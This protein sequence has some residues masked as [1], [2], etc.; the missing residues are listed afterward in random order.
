M[1]T[2]HEPVERNGIESG[3]CTRLQLG[4]PWNVRVAMTM[5]GLRSLIVG[6]IIGCIVLPIAADAEGLLYVETAGGSRLDSTREIVRWTH[7][8][9]VFE[10]DLERIAVGQPN[11]LE[12]ELL[13]GREALMLAKDIGTTSMIVWYTD[14]TTEPLVFGVIEDLSVLRRVLRDIHRSLTIELAPDRAAL[15]LRGT[16][17]DVE[18][19]AHAENAVR[20]YL[21]AEGAGTR[22]IYNPEAGTGGISS[23]ATRTAIINLIRTD[24]EAESLESRILAA[25]KPLAANVT[26]RRLV[27]GNVRDD[28]RDTFV[29]EGEV[30]DQV[31]LTRV[32]SMAS[33]I[34]SGSANPAISVVSDASGGLGT[35]GGEQRNIGRS[36]LLSVADG[37]VLSMIKVRFLPQVRVAVQIHEVNRS[38]LREWRPDLSLISS[39]YSAG[40]LSNLPGGI[41]APANLERLFT[42]DETE[43]GNALQVI[44]GTLTN[45]FQV[46]TSRLAFEVLFSILEEE[47]ISRSLASPTLTVL[48]GEPAVFE[49]GG[50]LPVPSVFVPYSGTVADGDSG[51]SGPGTYANVVFKRFGV[52]LKVF[53]LV[54]ESNFI[55]LD[56]NPEISQ[57]D[58]TLTRQITS[59]VGSRSQAAAFMTRSL[60]TRM[61]VRDGQPLVIGGLISQGDEDVEAYTPGL[62]NVPGVGLLGR[63]S[64]RTS[65]STELVIIVTPTIVQ[66]ANDQVALWQ[67]PELDALL[68]GAVGIPEVDVLPRILTPRGNEGARAKP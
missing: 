42:P 60:E 62:R 45:S 52:S 40:A 34:V 33:S 58:L 4:L 57:P 19:K 8:R 2:E 14:G 39:R 21:N 23:A 15:V 48:S 7:A 63:E 5:I 41:S 30:K 18:V 67:Y 53:P 64:S 55:T 13:G 61:R 38:R 1:R 10:K 46:G 65:Y 51:F 59:A 44:N 6:V 3:E 43:I 47:G 25:I 32:L 20:A 24:V 66:E 26:V 17:P 27:R 36:R 12:V 49:V 16:V 37:R 35:Q 28:A 29:L 31:T 9:L 68:D 56:I 50:Q 11:I 54:D 22:D